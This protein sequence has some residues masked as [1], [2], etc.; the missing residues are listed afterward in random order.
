MTASKNLDAYHELIVKKY[1]DE[2]IS[3]TKIAHEITSLGFSVSKNCIKLHLQKH[4]LYR[5]ERKLGIR[6]KSLDFKLKICTLCKQE[7]VPTSAPQK[8][9]KECIPNRSADSKFRTY[10]ISQIDFEQLLVAQ[11]N[12]CAICKRNFDFAIA[13]KKG[14]GIHVDHCHQTLKTRGILCNRCNHGLAWVEDVDWLKTAQEY[15]E[16][17]K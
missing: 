10:G 7:Y 8:R 5:E 17:Y 3:L 9:C 4:S 1:V 12:S 15:V 6:I 13:M 11:E 2:K 16:K 14:R